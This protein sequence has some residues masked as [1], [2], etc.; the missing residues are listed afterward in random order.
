MTP[1]AARTAVMVVLVAAALGTAALVVGLKRETAATAVS[2][3]PRLPSPVRPP[4]GVHFPVKGATATLTP[5]AE[6]PS[7]GTRAR[8]AEPDKPPQRAFA[9]Y[10]QHS[11][12]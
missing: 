3:Q 5:F 2:V 7:T 8:T 9:Q 4:A 1:T 12:R 11:G 6:L 10:P